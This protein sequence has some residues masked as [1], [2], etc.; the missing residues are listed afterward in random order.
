MAPFMHAFLNRKPSTFGETVIYSAPPE[1]SLLPTVSAATALPEPSPARTVSTLPASATAIPIRTQETTHVGAIV[2]ADGIVAI[3]LFNDLMH[4]EKALSAFIVDLG[5]RKRNEGNDEPV[6]VLAIGPIASPGQRP[7]TQ[8]LG[9]VIKAMT[10]FLVDTK[11][12]DLFRLLGANDHSEK[13]V[14]ATYLVK[15]G[16]IVWES[17]PTKASQPHDIDGLYKAIAHHS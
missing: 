16:S 12:S 10:V 5:I 4:N 11:S 3:V 8:Y 14:N 17:I 2:P 13:P 15:D 6:R 1:A 7:L 9:G